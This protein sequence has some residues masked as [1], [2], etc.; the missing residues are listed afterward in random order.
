MFRC[1]DDSDD[2][3]LV[4]DADVGLYLYRMG[5]EILPLNGEVE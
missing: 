1:F 4:I 2:V 3:G 5:D